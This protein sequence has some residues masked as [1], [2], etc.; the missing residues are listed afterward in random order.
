[1]AIV[2]CRIGPPVNQQF[3]VPLFAHPTVCL[4]FKPQWVY[5]IPTSQA[6]STLRRC[7]ITH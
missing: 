5:A 1:M 6:V 4:F 7:L 3:L 2:S